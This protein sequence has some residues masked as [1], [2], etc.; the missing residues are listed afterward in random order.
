MSLRWDRLDAVAAN[1]WSDLTNLLAEVD[2]TEE[3]YDPQDLAEELAESGVDPSQDTWAVRDGEQLIAFGQLRVRDGLTEGRVR[4]Y[5]GGG[6]HPDYRGQGIGRQ[7]MDRLEARAMELSA[8]RHP[9]VPVCLSVG[10]GLDS[11]PV[12]PMLVHRGYER[13]RYFHQMERALP[14]EQLPGEQLRGEQLR[15]EQSTDGQSTG[16]AYDIAP[17]TVEVY[18]AELA[19]PMRIAHNDAFST[20]F[21]FA[22]QSP[23]EWQDGISSRTFRP[24]CSMVIRDGADRNRVLCYVMA[25][26]Y[27]PG[28]LY[29]GRVGTIRSARGHGLAR[30]GLLETL[31]LAIAAG[32]SKAELD[33][34]SINPSGAGAL[35]ESVGFKRTKT[36]AVFDRVVPGRA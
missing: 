10:G 2:G 7:L 21:G 12:R 31:R 24:D 32:Y 20:H 5:L 14:G 19:E 30:A 36:T 6:V 9:G 17:L 33:V 15:G 29:I 27:A 13:V 23:Q 3:F 28:E 18:P 16:G 4:A 22:P 25:Y 35:Y 34:D 1:A 8:Q 26:S 11:D